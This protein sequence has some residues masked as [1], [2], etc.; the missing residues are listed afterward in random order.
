MKHF[1][2]IAQIEEHNDVLKKFITNDENDFFLVI[3]LYAN[4]VEDNNNV[5][6]IVNLS[7]TKL[8]KNIF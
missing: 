4:F 8:S 5:E 1:E 7:L 3:K 6:L 2:D